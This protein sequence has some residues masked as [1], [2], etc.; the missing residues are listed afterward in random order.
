MSHRILAVT[1]FALTAVSSAGA[2][3]PLPAPTPP[4]VTKPLFTWNDAILGAGFVAGTFALFPL[5]KHYADVLQEPGRQDNRFFK[6]AAT[7]FNTTAQPGSV[8][9]GVGLYT[10]GRL[11]KKERI[12]DLGLHGT[13]ALIAGALIADVLKIGFGRARPFVTG[14]DSV[15]NPGNWQ[16]MR[17]RKSGDFQ[18]FPSGHTTAAFAAAAAVTNET[19]RWWP[20]SQWYVGPIMFGGA[21]MVGASR[22]YNNRHWASDV[23]LGAAIGTFAGNKVVR[24]NHRTNPNNRLDRWLLSANVRPTSNGLQLSLSFIPTFTQ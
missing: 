7:F 16:F 23:M 20:G 22:M 10:Y 14:N 9:I 21:A 8:I 13:E 15:A 24:Y 19:S 3:T 12:A 17:G 6:D 4:P 2:Q 1:L 18:S 11:A 5:D